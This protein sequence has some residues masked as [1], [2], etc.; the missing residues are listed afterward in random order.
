[1]PSMT[2][3]A[4]PWLV[5]LAFVAMATPVDGQQAP[6]VA[7]GKLRV[8]V[9]ATA[10]GRTF[11]EG[12]RVLA[13]RVG[14]DSVSH[15]KLTQRSGIAEFDSMPRG[16]YVVR[17]YRIGFVPSV[18]TLDYEPSVGA[19]VVRAL[20]MAVIG[21]DPVTVGS[22]QTRRPAQPSEPQMMGARGPNILLFAK[23]AFGPA[24]PVCVIS[25]TGADSAAPCVLTVRP[26]LTFADSSP[27]H[28]NILHSAGVEGESR[29]RVVV[30]S[31]GGVAE[32]SH[33]EASHSLFTSAVQS[34]VAKAKFTPG[35]SGG[36][37]V[38]AAFEL[39]VIFR[40]VNPDSNAVGRS[41]EV[42]PE[43][44]KITLISPPPPRY[45]IRIPE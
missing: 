38:A 29:V 28:P 30:D 16:R 8:Q 42:T 2:P 23:P 3:T 39:K 7:A 19:S 31:V 37:P 40:F 45:W 27:R 17:V 10:D 20:R 41:V 43:G 35:H 6:P 13:S 1:M 14:D 22:G 33:I 26:T 15:E 9:I 11:A 25:R 21:I 12:S 34:A 5:A 36:R 4:R 18:D 32:V 24:T 44:Y